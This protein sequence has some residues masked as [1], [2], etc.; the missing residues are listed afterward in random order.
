VSASLVSDFV[1]HRDRTGCSRLT[2]A[3]RGKQYTRCLFR[4]SAASILQF[5]SRI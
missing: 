1:H 5:G 2:D 3:V 4:K